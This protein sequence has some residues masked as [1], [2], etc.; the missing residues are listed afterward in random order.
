MIYQIEAKF[1]NEK[2][3]L[4]I[5]TGFFD[6]GKKGMSRCGLQETPDDETE[7]EVIDFSL[8]D[9]AEVKLSSE[10]EESAIEALWEAYRRN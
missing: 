2:D 1:Y 6:E 8:V 5:A 3:Q 10:D 7:L 9:G 4:C